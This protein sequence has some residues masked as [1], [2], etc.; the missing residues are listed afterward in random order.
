MTQMNK[1][2]LIG[3]LLYK[4]EYAAIWLGFHVPSKTMVHYVVVNCSAAREILDLDRILSMSPKLRE[5]NHQTVLKYYKV[6]QKDSQVDIVLEHPPGGSLRNFLLTK[7]DQRIPEG[8][9]KMIF[10]QLT[11]GVDALHN[12]KIVHR[13]LN[14]KNIFLD[15]DLNVKVGD[16]LICHKIG[17]LQKSSQGSTSSYHF[18]AP[19]IWLSDSGPVTGSADVWSLGVILYVMTCGCY[20]FDGSDE[21]SLF[22]SIKSGRFALPSF[23]STELVGLLK[24]LLHPSPTSRPK[25]SDIKNHDWLLKETSTMPSAKS[26]ENTSSPMDL[27]SPNSPF[28]YPVANNNNINPALHSQFQQAQAQAPMHQSKSS[29]T[30][31]SPMVTSQLPTSPSPYYD[32]MSS[33]KQPVSKGRSSSFDGG[34]VFGGRGGSSGAFPPLPLQEQFTADRKRRYSSPEAP[35]GMPNYPVD[36]GSDQG[37]YQFR[38]QQQPVNMKPPSSL[39]TIPEEE[40]QDNGGFKGHSQGGY[41]SMNQYQAMQQQQQQPKYMGQQPMPNYGNPRMGGNMP[42]SNYGGYGGYDPS[43]SFNFKY[44][45]FPQQY[46]GMQQ[47][48]YPMQGYQGGYPQ[49]GMNQGQGMQQ[50]GYPFQPHNP[51][52]SSMSSQFGGMSIQNPSP[53]GGSPFGG[54]QQGG[55]Q[56]QQPSPQSNPSQS[57]FG[58]QTNS[59]YSSN[60]VTTV[61]SVPLVNN[62]DYQEL[63]GPNG[64][65]DTPSSSA[66]EQDPLSSLDTQGNTDQ[67]ADF[68]NNVFDPR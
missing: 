67:S 12:A 19:E 37:Q 44:P 49:Q 38:T 8:E 31:N 26:A 61:T 15:P 41:P 48:G 29:S 20:P 1:D 51:Y 22:W 60:P 34:H 9:A 28:G 46:G 53:R 66:Y 52:P 45:P 25:I 43:P 55:G 40:P 5:V 16:F 35:L 63:N 68:I 3:D 2:L 56:Q 18:Y 4:G 65:G 10:K 21:F 57:N 50:G 7:P 32:Q 23:L 17:P 33:A 39:E 42:P 47:G 24:L 11:D 54:Q 36:M 6:L 62:P 64:E 14:I 27:P 13:N 30:P 59:I 58:I